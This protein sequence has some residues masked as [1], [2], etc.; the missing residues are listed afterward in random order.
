MLGDPAAPPPPPF[1][2]HTQGKTLIQ[3]LFS[4]YMQL[5]T[6]TKIWHQ[7]NNVELYFH[8]KSLIKGASLQYN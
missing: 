3:E 8:G 4:L 6:E 1:L 5:A 2:P 7:L